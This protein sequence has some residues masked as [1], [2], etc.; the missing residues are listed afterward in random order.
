MHSC[1]KQWKINEYRSYKLNNGKRIQVKCKIP[2]RWNCAI[3]IRIDKITRVTHKL[4]K[5]TSYP[6]PYTTDV[7]CSGDINT[8]MTKLK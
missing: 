8:L 4:S 3:T 2:I 1:Y 7:V 5:R 6:E